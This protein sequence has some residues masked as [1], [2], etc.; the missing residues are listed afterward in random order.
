MDLADKRRCKLSEAVER[1]NNTCFPGGLLKFNTAGDEL[2]STSRCRYGFYDYVL[3]RMTTI[4]QELGNTCT[5]IER[6]T[7]RSS[8][9]VDS[10]QPRRGNVFTQDM[11]STFTRTGQTITRTTAY[12]DMVTTPTLV[13]C[14]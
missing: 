11:V 5:M 2:T 14:E 9:E 3:D 12:L 13:R 6:Q 4:C 7:F 8:C 10:D 1:M